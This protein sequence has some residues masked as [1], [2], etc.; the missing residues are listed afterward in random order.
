MKSFVIPL[1]DPQADLNTVGGK[2]MSLAKLTRSGLPVPDGFHVTTEA[3]RY[4]V[5]HNDLQTGINMSLEAVDITQPQTLEIASRKITELF[6]PAS[7]PDEI[8][9]AIT[10]GYASLPGSNPSVAVRSSATAE[11]LPDAS[12]AGQQETYLNIHH[13]EAVLDAVR[14]CWASLWTARAIGYRARQKIAP[15]DVALAV[16]VQELV[17]AEAAGILF[18]ANPINGQRDQMMVSASWGLGEAVVGGLV[19]PDSLI[20]EKPSGKV[21]NREIAQK[22]IQTV[23]IE[24]GTQEIQVPENLQNVPV[25]SDE[26]AGEL[27]QLGQRIEELYHMPMDIEWTL[28]KGKF[29]I[30][31]ARPITALPESPLDWPVP[32]GGVTFARGS[33]AEHTPSPVSPM[34]ATLGLRLANRETEI[35]WRDYINIDPTDM[36][37]SDGFYIT[38]NNY[39]YGGFRMGLKNSWALTKMSLS[40]IGPMLRGAP[41][42]WQEASEKFERVVNEWEGK[43]IAALSPSELL[44]GICTVFGAAVKYYTVIQTTLPAASMGEIF[45]TR[46]Y[47]ALIK[48]KNDPDA[49]TFLFGFKTMPVRAEQSLFDIASWV[50][51][52]SLFMQYMQETST[53]KLVADF[54]SDDIPKSV[55]ADQWAAY[56]F[57]FDQHFERFGRTAYEFD[58]ANPTPAEA[59]SPQFE[60]LK[61]FID[62]KAISPYDRYQEALEKR[63]KA[64]KSVLNRIGWPRKGW[65]EK[66][67]KKAHET[68][69]IREDSIFDMGMGHPV[70]RSMFAELGKLFVAGGAIKSADDIYWLEE[71]ELQTLITAIESEDPLPNYEDQIPRRKAEWRAALQIVPPVMLPEKSFWQRFIG[72]G[73]PEEKD[74]KTVLTG[75]GTSSGQVTAPACILHGPKDFPQMK[76]GD[77]LVATTTTPAWTPLFALASAVVTDIG[78]PLSHSSIVAR[79]YGIPAVMAARNAT[80]YI[81]NGQL[82]TVDGKAG[83]VMFTNNG[84]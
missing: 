75:L 13:P 63:E 64:T 60:A 46:F 9:T 39:V 62:G 74:G 30:V 14:K 33:L 78:G 26:Q 55:P 53:E 37:V 48:R 4:F 7:I 47:N 35:L 15:E 76:P 52:N 43:D 59:P 83:T 58:F 81:Q 34:F 3:Y 41:E 65:F 11:D 29:A 67:L 40:Q 27:C 17:F 28:A 49:T 73:A 22:L 54:K 23:R 20:L 66:L 71:Q 12:F 42:R 69:A 24:D 50:K 61:L 80:R 18:T 51:Q 21:I 19:T 56:R 44:D 5:E 82:V 1:S 6:L 77:V 16:V 36:F 70:I 2:G 45:F 79:E 31:Q 25:L 32:Q 57:R 72:G 68:G 10:Q 38:I 8:A 84:S